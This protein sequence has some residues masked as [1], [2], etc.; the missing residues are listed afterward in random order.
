MRV[1]AV[2]SIPFQIAFSGK[3]ILPTGAAGPVPRVPRARV[4]R[5]IL[6]VRMG[7]AAGH[8]GMV[9]EPGEANRTAR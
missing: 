7:P 4:F 3:I 1:T 9:A 6:P 2:E 8:A 5:R